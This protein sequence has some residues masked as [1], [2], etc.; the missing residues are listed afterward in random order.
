MKFTFEDKVQI[1][2]ERKCGSTLS[3]RQLK[4]NTPQSNIQYIIKLVDKHG[5]DILRHGYRDY[6]IQFKEETI[7]RVLILHESITSISID[8]GLSTSSILRRWIKEYK[9]NVFK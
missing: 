2:K 9:E 6:S 1:Y 7:H 3:Q 8:L 4:W 5:F